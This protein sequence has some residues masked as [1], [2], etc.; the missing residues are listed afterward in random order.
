[1][2]TTDT[3]AEKTAWGSQAPERKPFARD[4]LGVTIA[5]GRF[6]LAMLITAVSACFFFTLSLAGV[7]MPRARGRA[8]MLDVARW[9]ARVVLWAS[10]CPIDVQFHG[11]RPAGGFLFFANHQSMLDI[12][13]LFVALQDTP[14]A[15]AAKRELFR[16]PVIGWYLAIAG[17]V[18]V[19]RSDR[20]RAKAAYK[21][22]AGLL[23][24]GVRICIYPEGTRSID[25]SVLPF[26]KGPFVLAVEA[27]VPI[28]PV[29]VD[30]AQHAVP[31]HTLRL[32]G[33]T[34]HIRVGAPIETAGSTLESRD[35]LIVRT[36]K[37]VLALHLEAGAPPS[38][39]EPM[40]APPG[41][42]S[43]EREA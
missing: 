6:W 29:A 5:W 40:I 11:P 19:D 7:L 1:M 24:E 3:T 42:R 18:E 25:G 28:V 2:A 38:P 16:V 41:K 10:R 23:H 32:Y 8:W 9:W 17:Y 26:K 34:I 4:P 22:A 21:R 36:R 31:K 37:A 35:E 12:I 14:F 20:E 39:E 33:S 13:A 15:F 30:G 43:G 27:Q